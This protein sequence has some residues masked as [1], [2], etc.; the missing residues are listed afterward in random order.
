MLLIFLFGGTSFGAYRSI[1]S[2]L[3]RSDREA[4]IS[5]LGFG[6]ASKLLSS[7][8]PLGGYSGVELSVS[9]ESIPMGDVSA[10]GAKT[11]SRSDLSYLNFTLGKGL[12]N[13]VDILFHF[14]P[15]P[16]DQAVTGYGGQLR[17]SFYQARFMP[18][19]LSI[20]AHASSINFYNV[21]S[22]ETTGADLIASVNMQDLS[23]F[24]GLGQAR[25]VGYFIGG[26]GGITD[27]GTAESTDAYSTHT[28]FGISIRFSSLFLAMQVDRYV[29]STYSGKIGLRF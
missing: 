13:E 5:A 21:L 7:P 9:S 26:T 16:Q 23:L 8:Y 18:A 17:W 12:Y 28:L 2:G 4:A 29:Q 6:S 24:F 27:T 1:P 10:L 14:I 22:A 19:N 25:S 3:T 15:M 11:N 20:L